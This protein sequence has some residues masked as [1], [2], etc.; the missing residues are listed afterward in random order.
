[1][2]QQDNAAVDLTAA[3]AAKAV[4]RSVLQLSSKY[5]VTLHQLSRPPTRFY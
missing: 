2:H 3:Q 1:M 4:K 5:L